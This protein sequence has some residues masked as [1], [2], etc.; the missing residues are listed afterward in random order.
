MQALL[1]ASLL[2]AAAGVPFRFA[3]IFQDGMVLQRDVS[4]SVWGWSTPGALVYGELFNTMTNASVSVTASADSS[5]GLFVLTLPAQAGGVHRYTL[6][7]SS[8]AIPAKCQTYAFDCEGI[9]AYL[10]DIVFGDVVWCFGQSN[11]QVNVAFAFNSTEELALSNTYSDTVQIFQ[12]Q[13]SAQSKAGPVDDVIKVQLPWQAASNVS[14]PTFSATCWFTGKSIVDGRSGGDR[15]IPLGLV[16]STWGGTPVKTWTSPTVNAHCDALY[17]WNATTGSKD[18]GEYHAPCNASALYNTMVAPFTLGPMPLSAMVWFQGENDAVAAEYAFYACHLGRMIP[19]MRASFTS[20]NAHWTT[21]QL[22]PYIEGAGTDIAGFRDMQC[23]TTWAAAG[24]NSCAVLA[25][26]GDPLSPIGSVHS[27]NKQLVGRRVAPAI[28]AHVYGYATPTPA[29]LGP[30]YDTA[31]GGVDPSTGD[32]L[33]NVSFLPETVGSA[34]LQYVAPHVDAWQNSSRCPFE[35]PG[36]TAQQCGW[37]AVLGSD[38][39][40]YNATTVAAV[41]VYTLQL[42]APVSGGAGAGGG[43]GGGVSPVGTRW[44]YANWPVTNWYNSAGQP[45]LPWNKTM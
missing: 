42:R 34:G 2:A 29:L 23:T 8:R 3:S 31:V 15:S 45:M 13:A 16:A 35:L 44:G 43:G 10:L 26:D 9:S 32:L 18:C 12:V 11:M 6:V 1:A 20:P 4:A 37:F 21:V 7:V 5:S 14:L 39:V 25:D 30:R 22:A 17:P 36:V 24:N 38:G 41:D 27:R 19:D 28:L 33:V 40:Y